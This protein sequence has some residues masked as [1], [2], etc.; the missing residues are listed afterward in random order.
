[1]IGFIMLSAPMFA[2]MMNSTVKS[3]WMALN[4]C[5]YGYLLSKFIC[6]YALF[7]KESNKDEQVNSNYMEIIGKYKNI[8]FDKG[9]CL[10]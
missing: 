4:I 5:I 6:I 9:L 7:F 1:M 2:P 10:S 8:V 3:I